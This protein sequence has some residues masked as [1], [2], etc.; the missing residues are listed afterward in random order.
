MNGDKP[1]SIAAHSRKPIAPFRDF[2]PGFRTTIFQP[3][4]SR[5]AGKSHAAQWANA[6]GRRSSKQIQCLAART[7]RRPLWHASCKSSC[8]RSRTDRDEKS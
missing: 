8:K 3:R 2:A 5:Q 4:C 1:S 7:I 6:S